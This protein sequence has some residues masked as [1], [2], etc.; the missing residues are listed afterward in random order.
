M[1]DSLSNA[2]MHRQVKGRHLYEVLQLIRSESTELHLRKALARWVQRSH[3]G[4][5]P[6]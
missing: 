5:L 1:S 4:L 3:K 6:R 2:S